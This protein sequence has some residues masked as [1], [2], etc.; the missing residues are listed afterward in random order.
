VRYRSKEE[1]EFGD[2]YLSAL[3]P[4]SQVHP[5]FPQHLT[6][7]PDHLL[8]QHY[9][10]EPH[11]LLFESSCPTYLGDLLLDESTIWW[12][13][14]QYP[15][16]NI[17]RYHGCQVQDGR[18]TGFCFDKYHDNLMS[19]VNLGHFAKRHFD[20]SQRPLKVVKSFVEGTE[21]ALK[22]RHSLG[23]VHN[24]INRAD[25]MLASDHRFWL[26]QAC[27]PPSTGCVEDS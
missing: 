22:H 25:I 14:I 1:V 19:K 4:A 10:K 13:L 2:F 5:I 26:M 12:T 16:P 20:A 24:D 6:R 27:W 11:L 9:I 8:A 17:V 15:H 21:K 18:F 23:L 3:I 7:A